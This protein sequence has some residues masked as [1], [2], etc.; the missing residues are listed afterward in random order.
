MSGAADVEAR[1]RRLTDLQEIRALKALY[2][3]WVDSGYDA[4]GDDPAAFAALFTEDGVWA[5]GAEPAI[6]REAIAAR[7]AASR[8][9]R[10]HLAA[11]AI[12]DVA[13]G[14][15]SGTWH[16]LVPT[17]TAEGRAVWLAGTY[18]DTFVRTDAGWKFERVVFHTAFR[19]PYDEGWALTPFL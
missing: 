2:C 4:A 1:L 6:G 8:R 12:V 10:L 16:A 7:A 15:A 17:V 3:R 14:R 9:F 18:E 11:N 19:T 5:A 13:G